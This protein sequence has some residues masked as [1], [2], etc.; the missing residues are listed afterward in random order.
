[1]P[2]GLAAGIDA[3]VAGHRL[4]LDLAADP[5]AQR[6]VAADAFDVDLVAVE[7]ELQIAADAAD[8]R[9]ARRADGHDVAA[10]AF[11]VERTAGDALHVDV[12]GDPVDLQLRHLRYVQ[13][14]RCRLGTA[15][16]AR[17]AHLDF[18]A[19]AIAFDLQA[20]DAI[21]EAAGDPDFGFVPG[22]YLDAPLEVGDID[23]AAR[24]QRTRL[25]DGRCCEGRCDGQ[26]RQQGDGEG[27]GFHRDSP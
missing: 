27:Q 26:G 11:D 3:D 20:L 22:A 15:A 16:V 6:D 1:A 17:M 19:A 2:R 12:D 10:H 18:Q 24:I 23:A 8:V 7:V 21:T 9:L 4:G 14:Q 13:D 25:V 5:P